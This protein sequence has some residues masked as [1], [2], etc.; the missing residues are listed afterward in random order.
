MIEDRDSAD[1]S[2]EHD[3]RRRLEVII[4]ADRDHRRVHDLLHRP[5]LGRSAAFAVEL[6]HRVRKHGEEVALGDDACQLL[7][8]EHG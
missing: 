4:R 3:P 8:V 5:R 7:A 2:L 6:R 1:L